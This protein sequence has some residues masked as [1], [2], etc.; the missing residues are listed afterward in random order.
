MLNKIQ[1]REAK[2]FLSNDEL[3][4]LMGI[5]KDENKDSILSSLNKELLK[6]YFDILIKSQNI[7]L[8]FC[9]FAEE[10]IG[11]MVISKSPNDLINEFKVLKFQIFINLVSRLKIKSLINI[12]ISF[13]GLDM[14]FLSKEKDIVSK[15]LNLSLLAIKKRFQSKGIG[16][17]FVKKILKEISLKTGSKIITVETNN[18]Q[19]EK[20]YK[21]KIKFYFLGKKVR[22]FKNLSVL[23]KKIS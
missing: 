12:L 23:Y 20:F 14:I 9:K 8:F 7:S 4:F 3:N 13:T 2:K 16:Q 5:L 11:Y 6:K 18:N 22:L 19:A 17:F 15:N 21:E 1:T 10:D